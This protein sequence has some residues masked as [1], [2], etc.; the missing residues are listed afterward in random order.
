MSTIFYNIFKRLLVSSSKRRVL[1]SD[2]LSPLFRFIPTFIYFSLFLHLA[3]PVFLQIDLV[4]YSITWLLNLNFLYH[5][6]L[7]CPITCLWNSLQ[8]IFFPTI[9]SSFHSF[10]FTASAPAQSLSHVWLFVTLWTVALQASLSWDF[11]GKNTGRVAVSSSME[12]FLTQGSNPR[13]LHF[14]FGGGFFITVPLWKPPLSVCQ[15]L[16][17]HPYERTLGGLQEK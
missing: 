13:L 9:P 8:N 3:D 4:Y 17:F 11:P 6:I 10:L 15:H 2:L 14:C 1:C 16:N 12:I 5:L 7:C